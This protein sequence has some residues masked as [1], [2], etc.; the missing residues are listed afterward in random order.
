AWTAGFAFRQD[1]L[2]RAAELYR[3]AL[4]L[5]SPE[6][7]DARE[8]AWA[9]RMLG[10]VEAERGDHAES[11]ELL[12]EAEALFRELG[13][14]FALFAVLHDR[15]IGLLQQGDCARARPLLEQSAL[16]ARESGWLEILSNTL[17]DVGIL[18]LLERRRAEAGRVF[19]ESL[20][21]AVA[22]GLRSNI[23]LAL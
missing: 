18:E 17:L 2:D 10:L 21:L 23:H 11:A 13:D 12:E 4:D 1:E 8:H 14:R 22:R 7:A 6:G 3:R 20:E 19:A 5:G 16:E 15:G 9:L